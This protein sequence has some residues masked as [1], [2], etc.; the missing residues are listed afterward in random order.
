MKSEYEV[1]VILVC[2]FVNPDYAS[3][4]NYQKGAVGKSMFTARDHEQ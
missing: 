2:A 4:I 3:T 1:G